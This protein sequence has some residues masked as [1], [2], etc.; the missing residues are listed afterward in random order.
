MM[1]KAMIVLAMTE[2]AE[3]KQLFEGKR[4][5]ATE[6]GQSVKCKGFDGSWGHCNAGTDD[7]V[8]CHAPAELKDIDTP[9]FSTTALE[10]AL[11]MCEAS[12]TGP[13]EVVKAVRFFG[14]NAYHID[15][16]GEVCS[17]VDKTDVSMSGRRYEACQTC[18]I[19]KNSK[20]GRK[21]C[22]RAL[23]E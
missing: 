18:F 22:V 21:N 6:G 11:N 8:Y 5:L 19:T 1:L 15:H 7:I 20:S 23:V 14:D 3:G 2:T 16:L 10:I 12:Q 17:F 13:K 4:R 9:A